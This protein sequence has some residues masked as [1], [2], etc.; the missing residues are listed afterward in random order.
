MMKKVSHMLGVWSQK[1][2]KSIACY[3]DP[4]FKCVCVRSTIDGNVLTPRVACKHMQ[5]GKRRRWKTLQF[6]RLIWRRASCDFWVCEFQTMDS[7]CKQ[8]QLQLKGSLRALDNKLSLRPGNHPL[9]FLNNRSTT[10]QLL[11]AYEK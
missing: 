2:W 3:R 6:G 10:W 7:L 5:Q 4:N 11:G 8:L 9:Q 1:K